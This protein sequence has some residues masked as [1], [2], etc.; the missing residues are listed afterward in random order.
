MQES[1]TYLQ[2]LQQQFAQR[3]IDLWILMVPEAA[4]VYGPEIFKSDAAQL[5]AQGRTPLY[6]RMEKALA[7]KNIPAINGLRVLRP[8]VADDIAKGKL[9]YYRE[10]HHWTAQ[11]VDRIATAM[12]EAMR[13]SGIG[14]DDKRYLDS[15]RRDTLAETRK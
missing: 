4:S 13:R 7:E 3:G 2:W 11:G 14:S 12:A 5:Q 8:F 6:D 9:S 1:V 10:D 15:S